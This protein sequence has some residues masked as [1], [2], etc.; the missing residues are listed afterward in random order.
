MSPVWPPSVQC[1][2][3]AQPLMGEGASSHSSIS[4]T[5]KP[6]TPLRLT[7]SAFLQ[8][9]HPHPST[10]GKLRLGAGPPD[11]LERRLGPSFT[12]LGEHPGST[13]PGITNLWVNLSPALSLPT[14]FSQPHPQLSVPGLI[15]LRA[16]RQSAAL[17]HGILLWPLSL[18][19]WSSNYHSDMNHAQNTTA[20]AWTP[21]ALLPILLETAD[22]CTILSPAPETDQTP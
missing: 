14:A 19:L 7:P 22:S 15:P 13:G 20:P 1:P 9:L 17:G 6:H 10:V 5:S 18:C 16:P 11:D 4:R 3:I 8:E 12:R 21:P 2:S